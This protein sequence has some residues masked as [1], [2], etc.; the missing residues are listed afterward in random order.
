MAIHDF[1]Q[2]NKLE[3]AYAHIVRRRLLVISLFCLTLLA[4]VLS[5]IAIGPSNIPLADVIKGLVDP[6]TLTRTQR[7]I[8]WDVRL[9]YALLAVVVG[10]SLGLAGAEMQ[11]VLHNPLASPYTLGVSSAAT[12]GAALAIVLDPDLGFITQ[13]YV[14]PFFAILFALMA[15]LI[16]QVLARFYGA[17]ID[18]MVLFG[19]ALVFLCN[20]LVSLLQF[21]ATETA[22]EQIVFWT[23]GSLARATW[24]KVMVVGGVFLVVVILSMRQAWILTSLK[25]GEDQA[26][27]IGI[28]VDRLRLGVLLRVSTLAA[29]A[30]S[31][32]GAVGFIGL[33]GPHIARLS[34]GEDHRF[35]LPASALAGAVVLSL[36]SIAS[37]ALI[38]GLIMPVGIVTAMV[39]IPLFMSLVLM[40][41][42]NI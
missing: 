30:V 31:F 10:A 38:P 1:Q 7:I 22:L 23:M 24:P 39:G 27:S 32:V 28:A 29:V 17:G 20:A 16:I 37:K 33:V 21:V 19:I 35:Y 14:I 4:S 41:R 13:D 26:R 18:I 11:T 25:T 36:A 5:D 40:Q 42:R 6:D 8:L 2:A 3:L 9:P 34:L 12:L 15:S